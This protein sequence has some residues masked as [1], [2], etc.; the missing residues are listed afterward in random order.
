MPKYMEEI[1]LSKKRVLI[2]EDLNVPLN[3]DRVVSD[4]RILA[5]VPTLKLL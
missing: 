5:A 2:R 3:G 1:D 4:V